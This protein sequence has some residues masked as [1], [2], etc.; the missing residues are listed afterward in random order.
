MDLL[1]LSILHRLGGQVPLYH[2]SYLKGDGMV[3]F[4]QVQPGQLANLFQPIHQGVSVHEQLPGGFGHVQVVLEEAL[5]GH[6]GFS[7]QRVQAAILEDLL[8]EH[9]AQGGRQLINQTAD[10]QVFV[11]DDIL[12][13]IEYLAD[14]QGHLCFLIGAG[15][16]LDVVHDGTDTDGYLGVELGVQGIGDTFRYLF[17]F[18]DVGAGLDFLHQYDILLPGGDDVVLV[19]V[20]E[21]ILDHVKGQHVGLGVELDQEYH[22]GLL[23]VEAQLLG[24]DVDVAGENVVQDDVFDEGALVVLFIVQ[25][26]DVGKGYGQHRRD[27]FR[28]LVLPFDEYDILPLGTGADGLVGV[29]AGGNSVGGVGQLI[30]HALSHFSDFNKLAACDDDAVVIDHADHAVHSISHLVNDSLKQTIR[31]RMPLSEFFRKYR[32][33]YTILYFTV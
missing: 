7:V 31:H 15:Q 11:A 19:L 6:E 9:F 23:G 13:R 17:D 27:L 29:A 4:P 3:E 5:N 25:I 24:L 2:E 18:L 33:V 26:L 12:F 20:R 10:A 30:P 8:Q 1:V 21:D 32:I 14:L 22:P 16:V 28:E